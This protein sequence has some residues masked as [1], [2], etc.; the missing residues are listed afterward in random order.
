M[1]HALKTIPDYYQYIKDGSKTFEVRKNDR[2]FNVDDEIVLQEWDQLTERY[3]GEEWYGKIT[4]ILDSS[5]YCKKWF[6][7]LGIKP[8][9][10]ATG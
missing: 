8:R 2:P 5:E 4:F 9:T 7:I 10:E 1:L 6:V 3:T